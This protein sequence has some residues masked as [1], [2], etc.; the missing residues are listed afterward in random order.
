MI[1]AADQA[2]PG[3][4]LF[5]G[6]LT[7]ALCGDIAGCFDRDAIDAMSLGVGLFPAVCERAKQYDLSLTPSGNTGYARIV[8]LEKGG[9]RSGTKPALAPWPDLSPRASVER[10]PRRIDAGELLEAL[11][12]DRARQDAIL[13]PEFGV[14]HPDIDSTR[15]LPRLPA[16]ARPVVADL[17]ETRQRLK[18]T[19]P[20]AEDEGALQQRLAESLRTLESMV[21]DQSRR[22]EAARISAAA[23]R[24]EAVAASAEV[25][26]IVGGG[27]R[28]VWTDRAGI[29]VAR[30][31]RGNA[32]FAVRHD[33]MGRQILVEFDDGQ[34][35]PVVLYPG[36]QCLVLG[37]SAGVHALNYRPAFGHDESTTLTSRIVSE[38]ALGS[39]NAAALDRLATDLRHYKHI[40]PVF[41]AIAAYC[42]EVTGDLDSTRRMAYFYAM[43]GQP[44]PYD[45]AYMAM[46]END[47]VKARVPKVE[48][49]TQR[50]ARGLPM[51]LV[52]ATGAAEVKI[53]GRC[54][55]LRQGW[56]F[57]SAPEDVE[58]AMAG[59]LADLR[60]H[61]RASAFTTL[62]AAGGRELADR[63][64]LKPCL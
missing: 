28:Q 8:Y 42:Y 40:N 4:C 21:A 59:A 41:G 29:E 63:W 12:S 1:K 2:E 9:T 14:D 22:R 54:P 5:S 7:E 36:L 37:D 6:V 64:G 61:L 49:D 46:L 55:W 57:L 52:G 62:D 33:L 34:F 53:G 35:A 60:P 26:L 10:D 19:R 16:A 47:G 50:R 39:V 44:A 27:V 13:G 11:R 56:D 3:K 18:R 45:V 31:S 43:N 30:R 20:G 17:A 38:L 48:A 58:R 25:G 32:Q 15:P 51:W 24:L 23:R